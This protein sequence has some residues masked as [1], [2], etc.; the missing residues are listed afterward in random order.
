MAPFQKRPVSA[1]S[2]VAVVL[3]AIPKD[4]T[5]SKASLYRSLVSAGGPPGRNWF[6][7][8]RA[9][10]VTRDQCVNWGCLVPVRKLSNRPLIE[11]DMGLRP[12]VHTIYCSGD[13]YR[14]HQRAVF[15]GGPLSR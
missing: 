5:W 2:A 9:K 10:G 12:F 3:P 1:S 14:T 8:S 6:A 15:D 4:L 11:L 13:R 7:L